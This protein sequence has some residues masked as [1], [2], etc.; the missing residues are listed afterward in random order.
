MK[1]HGFFAKSVFG[2]HV[3]IV[4][5]IMTKLKRLIQG[6]AKNFAISNA[7]DVVARSVSVCKMIENASAQGKEASIFV[8][9]FLQI[10]GT[11]QRIQD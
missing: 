3:N 4:R 9:G 11:R 7:G 6:P 10:T 1:I 5:M 8:C 2:Y